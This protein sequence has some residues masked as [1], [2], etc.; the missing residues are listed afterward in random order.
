MYPASKGALVLEVIGDDVLMAFFK[1]KILT[2]KGRHLL[3]QQLK[4]GGRYLPDDGVVYVIISMDDAV[5]EANQ[6]RRIV[7]AFVDLR[8]AVAQT[9]AGLARHFKP[10]LDCGAALRVG[11]V[12]N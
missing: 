10:A 1:R 6:A 8:E 5:A 7:E 12:S 4:F 3:P 11:L 9:H 2:K